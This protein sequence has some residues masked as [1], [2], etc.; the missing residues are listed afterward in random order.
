MGIV[1]CFTSCKTTLSSTNKTIP[2]FSGVF[3]DPYQNIEIRLAETGTFSVLNGAR[4]KGIAMIACCDTIAFGSWKMINESVI[5]LNSTENYLRPILKTRIEESERVYNDSIQFI[6]HS[7]IETH[8]NRYPDHKRDFVYLFS[9]H[10][11]NYNYDA[12]QFEI[13]HR[14]NPINLPFPRSLSIKQ[15]HVEVIPTFEFDGQHLGA[16][17]FL[18]SFYEVQNS[19]A[20][21]FD[22]YFPELSYPFMTY[23]RLDQEY[24]LRKNKNELVWDGVVYHR[25]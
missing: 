20:N 18:S 9:L 10:T 13:A 1:F 23:L 22:I 25:K 21:T 8:L 17:K 6:F 15:I 7:P 11:G 4:E 5:E 14:K 2:L 19:K 12:H 3:L 24:I 16:R